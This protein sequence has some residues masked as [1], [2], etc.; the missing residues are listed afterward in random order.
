MIIDALSRNDIVSAVA[1]IQSIISQIN[2][3][4]TPVVEKMFYYITCNKYD[5]VFRN[6]ATDE[7]VSYN[8]IMQE[9]EN[10]KK[11][12]VKLNEEDETE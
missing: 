3:I 12:E 6:T 11:A 7:L 2:L 5:T 9:I 8:T 1:I 4:D 10:N